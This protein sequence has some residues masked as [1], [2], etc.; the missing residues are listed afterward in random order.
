VV[1]IGLV[2]AVAVAV[3]VDGHITEVVAQVSSSLCWKMQKT[4]LPALA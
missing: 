2:V 3:V 1:Q 4:L